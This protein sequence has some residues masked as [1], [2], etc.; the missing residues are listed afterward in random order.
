VEL[1]QR[2]EALRRERWTGVRIAFEREIH[3]YHRYRSLQ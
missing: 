1:V 2:V 3:H